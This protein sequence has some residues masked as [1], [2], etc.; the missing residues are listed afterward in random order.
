M[1]KHSK[2]LYAADC[3]CG[4][5]LG[6]LS[7]LR[8][9]TQGTLPGP[10]SIYLYIYSLG[11][12]TPAHFRH[13]SHRAWRKMWNVT[14]GTKGWND[15]MSSRCRK[16]CWFGVVG[17]SMFVGLGMHISQWWGRCRWLWQLFHLLNLQETSRL[18]EHCISVERIFNSVNRSLPPLAQAV[19]QRDHSFSSLPY[20]LPILFLLAVQ[21][22]QSSYLCISHLY[23]FTIILSSYP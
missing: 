22:F 12:A 18:E 7:Y 8:H 11:V 3:L 19:K 4:S 2:N 21:L 13:S 15:K 23:F 20:H 17:P 5:S 10:L 1:L 16:F 9:L 14:L 6:L